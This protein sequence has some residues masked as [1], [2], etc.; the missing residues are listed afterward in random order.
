MTSI[1]RLLRK[2]VDMMC[3]GMHQHMTNIPSKK[4][5]QHCRGSVERDPS[6]ILDATIDS[7]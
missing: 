1:T 3:Y 5:H 2:L 6:I 4:H 7:V